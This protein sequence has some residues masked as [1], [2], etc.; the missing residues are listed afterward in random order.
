M[1]GDLWEIYK[2]KLKTP[3]EVAECVSQ[4]AVCASDIALSN[5]LLIYNAIA[6]RVLKGELKNVTHHTLLDLED[7]PFYR[8]EISKN[9][10]SVS[11]FTQSFGRKA[12]NKGLAD[13]MPCYY[14]K[15][16]DHFRNYV[17]PDT[18]IAVVS[19][20]DKH[21]FLSTGTSASNSQAM[22]DVAK[23]ILLEVNPNMPRA[24]SGPQIHIS[25][26]TA[27]C[28]NDAPL[29]TLNPSPIDPISKKI[30]NYISDEICDGATLQLGIGKI[31]DAVG[32]A[33]KGKHHLGI[34]T[35]MFT[36]SMMELIECGA[37]DNSQKP[38][39][40]GKSVAA[41]ALGSRKMYDYIDDNPAM[42]M[43]TVD[44]VNDPHVIAMHPNFM[45]VNGALE[46]DFYGQVSAESVGTRHISGTGGHLDYV[47][48]AVN[49]P[50][51]KSFVAFFSTAKNETESRIVATL[52]P[53]SCVSTGKNDVD[54]IVTEYGIARLRG[55]TLS[56]RTKELINIAHPK[57]REELLFAA[58][59]EN[60]IV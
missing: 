7:Y 15:M 36:D 26:V 58:K 22:I 42:Q 17:K 6:Q 2:S 11:W 21:G 5:S 28:E 34:H 53:G 31:P 4:G 10:R 29:I 59:K 24:L 37:V 41:F 12:V 56:E 33:L 48:G 40:T 14:S 13:V 54:N 32:L 20:M 30:G 51:G 9:F 38:I 45:S 52:K 8:P 46:V 43:M 44:Y 27:L 60:I 18:F 57:F 3:S 50:G 23:T 1:M 19:P 25:K 47:R 39:N 55:K 16:P 35:E 49:S